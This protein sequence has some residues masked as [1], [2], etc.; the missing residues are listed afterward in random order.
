M[1]RHESHLEEHSKQWEHQ[2][3]DRYKL[4][5]R[6]MNRRVELWND[7]EIVTTLT[8]PGALRTALR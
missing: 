5:D 1:E 7:K 4:F 8:E 3:Q 6:F 2:K